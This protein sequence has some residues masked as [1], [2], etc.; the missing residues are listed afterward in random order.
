MALDFDGTLAPIAP[1]PAQAVMP[2]S[3]AATIHNL[4]AAQNVTVAIVSGRSVVDLQ[5][6]FGPKVIC[7]GNHGLELQGRGMAFVHQR[8]EIFRDTLAYA[9]WDLGAL[10]HGVPGVWVEPKGLTAT[11][12]YRQAPADLS[13]WIEAA[14]RMTLE[15]YEPCLTLRPALKAWEVHPRTGWN[16]ASA[17]SLVLDLLK[18]RRALLV[19]AGDDVSDEDVF[20][21]FP[22]AISIRVGGDEAVPTAARYNVHDPSELAEFLALIASLRCKKETTA[23]PPIAC[24][25]QA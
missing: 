9:S 19:T 14:I 2:R 23:A 11:V 20:R 6:R 8:A 4:A 15:A 5:T 18:S 21:A 12:H 10:L 22:E 24:K 3:T 17:L 1:S 7:V 16:K 25:Q 13:G